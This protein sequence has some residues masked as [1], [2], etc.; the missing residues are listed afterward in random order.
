MRLDGIET[1]YWAAKLGSV[2]EAGRRLNVSQTAAGSRIA[3]LE[4]E[5]GK[6]LLERRPHRCVRLTRD[7]ER[8]LA[9]AEALLL[10]WRKVRSELGGARPATTLRVGAIESAL[11]AWLVPWLGAARATAPH[12]RIELTV[13]TTPLLGDALRRGGLDVAVMAHPA[14]GDGVRTRA[15][16]SMEMAFVGSGR[17]HTRRS[18]T[19][20][21]I[22]EQGLVTFQRGSQPH[23][24][25]ID[26]LGEHGLHGRSTV[27]A[28]SSVSAMARMVEAGLGIA[29]LPRATLPDLCGA[30][31]LRA[32][33]CTVELPP[34]P[35]YLCWREDPSS[36]ELAGVLESA[37]AHAERPPLRPAATA[38]PNAAAAARTRTSKPRTAARASESSRGRT[39]ARTD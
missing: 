8:F 25:L 38:M 34:L 26:V 20:A 15:L 27:H 16:P 37:A 18:Y 32:L 39:R 28:V 30:H 12:L 5:L 31:A 3:V 13:E 19:L 33:S 17:H 6:S 14:S 10:L 2:T 21:S 11:H 1:F 23:R 7:G 35:L 4:R 36:L 9:D 29:T 24:A 22:A